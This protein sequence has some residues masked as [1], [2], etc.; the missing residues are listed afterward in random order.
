[1]AE[2]ASG[3]SCQLELRVDLT[4]GR[5]G[6]RRPFGK[7]VIG[8]QELGVRSALARRWIPERSVSKDTVG[9]I[10]VSRTLMV[11][12]PVLHWRWVDVVRFAPGSAF[13]DVWLKVPTRSRVADELRRRGYPVVYDR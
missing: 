2:R 9:K 6:V 4:A 8:D 10:T 1:V 12:L 13:A 11:Y 5:R 7:F 3:G